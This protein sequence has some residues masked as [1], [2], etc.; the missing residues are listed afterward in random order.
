MWRLIKGLLWLVFSLVPVVLVAGGV[1]ILWLSRSVVPYS[2]SAPIA[3][4]SGPVT[5]TR[6]RNDVPHIRGHSIEDVLAALGY[7]H[8]QERLWQ[9]E[10]LRMASRGRLSELFG[11]PTIGTDVFLRSLGLH[12]AAQASFEMLDEPSKRRIEAYV[13]GV[14]AFIDGEGRFFASKFSPEFAILR[15]SP[16]PW[17]PADVVACLKMLSVTLGSNI[18]EEILRLKFARLG[19]ND[20][21]I[22][23]LLPPVAG[24][25]PPPLPDLRVLLGLASGPLRAKTGDD[26]SVADF[27]PDVETGASNNWV[28]SGSR[29]ASG[30]PILANDPH[31]GLTAPGTWYLAHLQWAADGGKTRNLVGVTLPGVPLVLL[32]RND[33]IAWGFT[34]TNADVQDLFVERINP[35]DPAEYLTPDG[36]RPFETKQERIKVKGADD[37]V[38]M[39]RATRHGPVLPDGF[40]DLRRFLPDGTVA[41]LSWTALAQNDTTIVAGLRAWDYHSVQDFFDGMRLY[42]APVQSMVVADRSGNIGM[43]APGRIPVRDPANHVAGRA[44][45]PGWDRTYDWKG[46]IP[47]EELPRVLNPTAGAVATSNTKMVG[48]GYPHLV[49][50]DW[51]EPW[52]QKRIDEL[53]VDAAGKQTMATSRNAQADDY[54]PAFAALAPAMLALVRDR[55]DVGPDAI[56]TIADWDH[57]MSAS[58]R[59]PLVFTAWVREVTKRILSDDLGEVFPGYWQARVDAMLRWLSPGAARDWCDDRRTPVKESC[60]D[61]LAEA[62]NDALNDIGDRLGR[63]RSTWRWDALHYAYGAHQPFSRVKPL[64]RFFDVT[65][66]VAGGPFTLLRGKSDFADEADPYRV[67]HAASYRGIFDLSDLDR[68][69]Y[70]QTTGQSGNVF[71]PHYR[72]FAQ[73]WANVEAVTIPT[74]QRTYTDG[75]L[76]TWRLLPAR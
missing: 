40:R 19:M 76:G 26:F 2:G 61:I 24:D 32:G 59:A 21:E 6:D 73:R 72:D 55:A 52:R 60:G 29:T 41:A 8:A 68:S 31:L 36:Y 51:D 12:E 7:T 74:D 75:L 9:M 39:R 3:G 65:V 10:V 30:S 35:D 28:V 15:H 16:E 34:T 69:T 38:F 4:L 22:S 20:S 44:P 47:F 64:D 46:M 54:S 1:G 58:G 63:D 67:T 13:R 57:R 18:G 11:K 71:S 5:V 27:E 25:A 43:I 48:P 14:N 70:I 50:Y 45:A 37:Y 56:A 42:V 62:L 33:D 66:P 23:D 49:T 53:I 17:T